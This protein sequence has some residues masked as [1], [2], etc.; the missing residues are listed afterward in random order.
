M[1]AVL[2]SYYFDDFMIHMKESLSKSIETHLL[3]PSSSKSFLEKHPNRLRNN[4]YLFNKYRLTNPKT[5]T[6]AY[7][8]AQHIKK[9]NP[10]IIHIQ[11]A[12]W[13]RILLIM[14]FCRDYKIILSLHDPYT[15]LGEHSF[16][17]TFGKKEVLA[18]ANGIITHGEKMYDYCIKNNISKAEITTSIP[19]GELSLYK[20]YNPIPNNLE[21]EEKYKSGIFVLL[22]FG[23]FFEY[24]GL[25]L[26]LKAEELMRK[27]GEKGFSILLAGRG[28]DL[29]FHYEQ[30]YKNSNIILIDDYI[31][32]ASVSYIFEN[33]SAV[34][35]PY[36]EATQ[37]G[38]IPLSYSFGKPIIATDVGSISEFI[39]DGKTGK[40]VKAG[41]P[42]DLA[43]K[44]I[45]LKN[46]K[47]LLS[48][49]SLNS[50]N[51]SQTK[52]SW[53]GIAKTNISFYKKIY[54]K[55]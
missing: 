5:I 39:I 49:M 10:D 35:L 11:A 29:D 45:N 33:S 16:F 25:S 27:K 55:Q 53:K 23:R 7:R 34:V 20:D 2:L 19:L 21:I 54:G 18:R 24:K 9:I 13:V 41:D 3:M 37:S 6:E 43:E 52:L 31:D 30:I 38:V 46:N 8:I 26:L 22:M 1:K 47:T 28:P 48:K 40:L 4:V 51:Y 14:Y 17:K 42:K 12:D 32:N 50:L 36:V 15:H 44:I